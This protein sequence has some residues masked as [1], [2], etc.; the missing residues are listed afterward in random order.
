MGVSIRALFQAGVQ[1]GKI[2]DREFR[3][4]ELKEKKQ[5]SWFKPPAVKHPGR[6]S[7]EIEEE[8]DK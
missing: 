8:S 2:P 7:I 5:P 3:E 1:E 4:I 6:H